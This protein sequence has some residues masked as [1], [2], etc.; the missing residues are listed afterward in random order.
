MLHLLLLVFFLNKNIGLN[1]HFI[2]FPLVTQIILLCQNLLFK[3]FFEVILMQLGIIMIG[4]S[5]AI[6]FYDQKLIYCH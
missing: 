2:I 6:G 4:L 1:K 5:L 3:Y